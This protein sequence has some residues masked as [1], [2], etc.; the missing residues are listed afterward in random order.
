MPHLRRLHTTV[1]APRY[2]AAAVYRRGKNV[3]RKEEEKDERQN[4]SGHT[5]KNDNKKATR[6]RENDRTN[7]Q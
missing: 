3:K 2:L 7:A 6:K 4:A 5:Q 1:V